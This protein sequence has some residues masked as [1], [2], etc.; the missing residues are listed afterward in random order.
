MTSY[1]VIIGRFQ[2]ADLH[3][4]HRYL[5]DTAIKSHDQLLIIL[6]VTGGEATNRNPLDAKTREQMIKRH[7]PNA[8]VRTL[9]DQASDEVWSQK[10][11]AIITEI[12]LGTATIYGSRD[13][14]A[15][16]YR[17]RYKVELLNEIPMISGERSR[18][19]IADRPLDDQIFRLGMIYAQQIRFPASYQTVDIVV[20]RK[21]T[22]EILLGRKDDETTWRF[23]G[24]FVDPTDES[25]EL[26]AKRECYEETGGIEIDMPKYIGSTRINDHRYRNSDDGIMTAI[27]TAQY[28]FGAPRATDDLAELKWV[29]IEDVEAQL[30]PNH[31][32]IWKKAAN[33]IRQAI[34]P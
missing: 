29:R 21:E 31:Q 16:H 15:S 22:G 32:I 30:A 26:A 5:I 23:I 3:A 12:T 20:Y 28:I 2:V 25:L 10:L 9:N 18:R 13:C 14:F 33:S 1:A 19:G 34:A 4:G 17:G 27:F 7:Y 6:G 8:I 24:G 11:D